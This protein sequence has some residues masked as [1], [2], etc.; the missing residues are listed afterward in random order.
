VQLGKI[1]RFGLMELS[2]QRLRPS[3][4]ESSH[5]ACPRCHGTGHIRGTESTALH[6]LRIL[7]EE[8]MK[9][10][11]AAVHAQVPVDVATFLLNEKRHDIQQLETRHRVTVTLIPNTHLETPNYTITRMRH[12]DLNNSEPLPPSYAMVKAP[13]EA[14]KPSTAAEA[15]APRQEAAVKGITPP[16]RLPAQPAAAPAAAP[17]TP[18]PV[19]P[20]PGEQPSIIGK[21]FG[22]FRRKPEASVAT[23]TVAATA[24]VAATA[25]GEKREEG[26]RDRSRQGPRRDREDHRSGGGRNRHRSER[27]ERDSAERGD[28]AERPNRNDRNERSE[29]GERN[30]P[31][32]AQPA[33]R[34]DHEPAP[35]AP[36]QALA[37]TEGVAA[38][39]TQEHAAGGNGEGRGRRRRGRGRGERPEGQRQDN[40][41]Q[42]VA[43]ATAGATEGAPA[44]EPREPRE[45]R[46]ER[47]YRYPRTPFV[48]RPRI[49]LEGET[50]DET[51]VESG[52]ST[53]AVPMPVMSPVALAALETAVPAPVTAAMPAPTV[54]PALPEI[55]MPV[56]PPIS[57]TP[58][59]DPV[60]MPLE[61]PVVAAI[62]APV[63]AAA[64]PAPA[65]VVTAAPVPA[66]ISVAPTPVVVPAPLKLDGAGGLTQIETD[67]AKALAAQAATA[68]AVETPRV[69]RTRPILPPSVEEPLMQVETQRAA[70]PA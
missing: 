60:A 19:A 27:G 33:P 37:A 42:A 62:P 54:M 16:E 61:A 50:A 57:G 29:R 69:R 70:P 45:P 38:A 23:A 4:G 49:G 31:Q 53:A 6:I 59:V 5:E 11:T 56:A 36:V 55:P 20:Q 48:P 64:A 39:P 66:P 52:D 1:S 13:E 40:D 30:P 46:G 34:R 14:E 58:H 32:R 63:I 67:H 51:A 18:A 7:Q 2:R 17:E 44:R 3:L 47:K 43:P 68:T 26:R 41:V 12:D 35:D 28:R 9:E 25:T 21:I 10:S 22:W 15:A 65:P 24:A 8:S